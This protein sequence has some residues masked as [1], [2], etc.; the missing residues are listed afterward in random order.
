MPVTNT[1]NL[2]E[3]EPTKHTKLRPAG[4]KRHQRNL[5]PLL[6]QYG[7]ETRGDTNKQRISLTEVSIIRHLIN[8]VQRYG[9]Y[10][11]TAQEYGLLQQ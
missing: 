3:S 6:R 4:T 8:G 11:H 1:G 10:T 9:R 2:P 7:V 5:S